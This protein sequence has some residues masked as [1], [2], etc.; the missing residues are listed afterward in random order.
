MDFI[1]WQFQ[2]H[3]TTQ[4]ICTISRSELTDN[5]TAELWHFYTRIGSDDGSA[6]GENR[7]QIKRIWVTQSVISW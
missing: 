3:Y 7:C 1:A 5:N 2:Q 6:I 4:R